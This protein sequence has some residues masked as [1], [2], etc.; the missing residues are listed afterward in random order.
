[1][2]EFQSR[3]VY[4]WKAVRKATQEKELVIK[5]RKKNVLTRLQR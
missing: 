1:M 2:D 5:E 3:N 4:G